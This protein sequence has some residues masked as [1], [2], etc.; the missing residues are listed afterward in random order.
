MAITAETRKAII[1]LVV[2]AYNQAPGTTL[3]NELVAIVDAG[4]TLADVATSLTTSDTWSATYPAFQT[5]EEFATE[6]LGTLVPEASAVALAEGV[7]I[8]VGLV[9]GG[10][11]FADIIIVAQEFL[12]ALPET[13]ASFGTS[14]AGFNNKVEVAT[15]HTITQEI[16]AAGTD[17]L[18]GV[19][20]TE[21]SV[22][23]AKAAVDTAEVTPGTTFTLTTA[24]DNKTMGAGDDQAFATDSLTAASDTFNVSDKIDGGAGEDT[25]FLT[26]NDNT[27]DVSYTPSRISNFETLSIT[28][29][30]DAESIS[31]NASLMGIT[32]VQNSASSKP[33]TVTGVAAGT[34]LDAMGNTGDTTLTVLGAGL[35]GLE[36]TAVISLTGNTGAIS[37]TSSTAQDIEKAAF[38]VTG[39]NSGAITITDSG[40]NSAVTSATVSGS[41]SYDMESGGGTFDDV[42]TTLDAS[43]NTGGVT[44][45]ATVSTGASLTGGAGND[46]LT[47][48]AGNDVIKGGAGDDT[49]RET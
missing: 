27:A 36:D 43:A 18:S 37:Y 6:W 17:T 1:E 24:L 22:T 2:T 47:G 5:A 49:L 3:L 25:F 20:S 30:D 29:I 38:T 16:A 21:G 44:F 32:G 8:A 4:G 13:D 19:D 48:A 7:D 39:V 23:T 11:S 40:A 45:T 15:Y 31:V 26:F 42:L 41:G 12:S 10:A 9:N 14:A 33:V 34:T 28:N 35:T 46:V